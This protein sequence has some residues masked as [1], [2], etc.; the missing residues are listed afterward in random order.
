MYGAD[1]ASALGR[2]GEALKNSQIAL[3]EWDD[4]YGERYTSR[5]LQARRPDDDR[6]LVDDSV[7]VK[8]ALPRRIG[9]LQQASRFAG[10][11]A[12]ERG[13]WLLARDRFDEA[14]NVLDG[15]VG[16]ARG[17]PLEPI[18][19]M[20]SHRASLITRSGSRTSRMQEETSRLLF[21]ARTA[22]R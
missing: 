14:R 12:L 2:V 18:A 1:V 15:A 7:V 13:R 10:G 21:G 20:A 8:E 3:A 4:D 19:R 11:A 22:L 17:T 5:G 9:E 16:Q 6:L